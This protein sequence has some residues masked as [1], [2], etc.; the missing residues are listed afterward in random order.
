MTN[1]IIHSLRIKAEG[2]CQKIRE[3]PIMVGR[4]G[5]GGG[6]PAQESKQGANVGHT[7]KSK[8]ETDLCYFLC[9]CFALDKTSSRFSAMSD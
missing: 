8:L 1:K 9:T 4:G 7:F 5:G 2:P 6:P 3:R